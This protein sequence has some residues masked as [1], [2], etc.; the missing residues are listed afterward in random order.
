MTHSFGTGLTAALAVSSALVLA[1]PAAPLAADL[2]I[3]TINDLTVVNGGV[4]L[5]ESEAI[6]RAASQFSLRVVISGRSGDYHVAD[7]LTITRQGTPVL[8]LNDA[9]PWLLVNLPPGQYLLKGVF[10]GQQISRPVTVTAAGTTAH[11]V[12][13]ASLP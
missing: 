9:G 11:W 8:A 1:S 3:E 6:K 2:P 4:G 12:L 13:P 5:D 10:D 7:R